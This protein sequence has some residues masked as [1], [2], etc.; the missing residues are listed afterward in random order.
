MVGFRTFILHRE[1]HCVSR[2]PHLSIKVR[3]KTSSPP[4]SPKGTL[5]RQLPVPRPFDYI[6]LRVP[7]KQDLL[8]KQSHI[9]LKFPEQPPLHGPLMG[10]RCPFPEPSF[11]YS[12]GHPSPRFPSQNSYRRHALHFQSS[13]SSFSQRPQ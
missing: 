1:R 5:W 2:T 12:S 7:N 4:G 9:S 8:K 10:E 6:F 3:A 13:A 11:T